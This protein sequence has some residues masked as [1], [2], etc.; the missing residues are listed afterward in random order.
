MAKSGY[1][2][3][4]F[5]HPHLATHGDRLTSILAVRV[6]TVRLEKH[7]VVKMI[8]TMTLRM[9]K[10]VRMRLRMTWFCWHFLFSRILLSVLLTLRACP[11]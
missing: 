6:K 11:Q 10:M 3:V 5:R 8:R 9:K 7:L 1:L 2:E 4:L